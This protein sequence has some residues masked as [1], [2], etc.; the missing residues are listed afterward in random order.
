MTGEE[1][2]E[3]RGILLHFWRGARRDKRWWGSLADA[4]ARKRVS[5][6]AVVGCFVFGVAAGVALWLWW[7][8]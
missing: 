2:S 4:P 3:R 7:G 1:M 6:F 8:A 5:L